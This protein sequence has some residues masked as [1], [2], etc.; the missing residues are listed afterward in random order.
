MDNENKPPAWDDELLDALFG[1]L[2]SPTG[3][4]HLAGQTLDPEGKSIRISPVSSRTHTISVGPFSV[5]PEVMSILTGIAK[6]ELPHLSLDTQT[7]NKKGPTM[8]DTIKT[9][10][11]AVTR[12]TEGRYEDGTVVRFTYWY[13]Q[14]DT[15]LT[16]AALWVTE[17][18]RWYLTSGTGRLPWGGPLA[19]TDEDFVELLSTQAVQDMQVAESWVEL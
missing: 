12:A 16:Y 6:E 8:Q 3:S 17:T 10:R 1:A 13:E 14:A 18:K 15:Q 5:S 7:T 4:T 2:P 9:L 11:K 19:M